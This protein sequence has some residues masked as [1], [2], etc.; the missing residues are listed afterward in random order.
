MAFMKLDVYKQDVHMNFEKFPIIHLKNTNLSQYDD[1]FESEWEWQM[2]CLGDWKTVGL[3]SF[4]NCDQTHN[5]SE[6]AG[7]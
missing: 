7:G 1:L 4:S 3:K 6:A 5:S 2:L